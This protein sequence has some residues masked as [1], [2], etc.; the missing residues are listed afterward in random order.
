MMDNQKKNKEIKIRK[1]NF[2]NA[3]RFNMS[4]KPKKINSYSPYSNKK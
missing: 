4:K 2:K 1:I 3:K